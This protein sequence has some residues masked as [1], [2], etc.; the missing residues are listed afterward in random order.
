MK[1]LPN[2]AILTLVCLFS[3]IARAALFV[4]D[5]PGG[6]SYHLA[7]LTDGTTNAI[8]ELLEQYDAFVT[9]DAAKNADLVDIEWRA[10]GSTAH[11][12][13]SEHLDIKGPVYRIDGVQ[14]ADNERDL[15]D[16][17]LDAP[18]NVTPSG[19]R[20]VD[21]T[22]WT[23]ATRSGGRATC[24]TVSPMKEC[25]LGLPDAESQVMAAISSSA[26]N[27]DWI[28]GYESH[29]WTRQKRMYAISAELMVPQVS[30]PGDF[31][32]DG[33]LDATDINDLTAKSAAGVYD[34]PYDL[35]TDLAVNS[36]DVAMWVK[37]L[38]K[39]WIGD[40]NLDKEFS[41]A[42]LVDVLASGTYENNINAVWTTGDFDGSGRTNTSDLVAA[43]ADGG[44]ERGPVAAV[45]SV[46]E[47]SSALLLVIGCLAMWRRRGAVG[48]A[49][50]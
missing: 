15:W 4:P 17:S 25:A 19:A 47:P 11:V 45:A 38:F 43:L 27:S 48:V 10:V 2:V 34:A 5:L 18:L 22:V 28:T 6:S 8:N 24:T 50:N 20:N 14:I 23:G 37:D 26:T 13:A 32:D 49:G 21:E 3:G 39:S 16:G 42:D 30:I 33:V 9:A 35:N 36:A 41:S 7:F 40:A 44:Y 31:N 12:T 29:S 46:P 1:W